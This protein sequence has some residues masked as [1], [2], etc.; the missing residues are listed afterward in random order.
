LYLQWKSTIARHNFSLRDGALTGKI[1]DSGCDYN[2]R[3]ARRLVVVMN[4][5]SALH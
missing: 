5:Q 1:T 2:R 3:S 4:N